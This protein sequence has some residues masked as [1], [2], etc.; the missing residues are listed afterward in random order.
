VP[1]ND[2]V[3]KTE[4]YQQLD[5]QIKAASPSEAVR[6]E[7]LQNLVR[8]TLASGLLFSAGSSELDAAGNATLAK[9]APALKEL[10]G[11]R[12]VIVGY[13]DDV[14]LGPTPQERF[15][16]NVELSK[17]RARAVAAALAAQGV[18][19][20]LIATVG[21]GETHPAASN[22]TSAGRAQNRR[23]EIDVVE[24]PA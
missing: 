6:I 15:G 3:P 1:Y 7:Q 24:A 9:L 21:L 5:A 13:T 23:V 2:L 20:G 11:Q 17:A 22:D 16:G 19:A 4:T 8:V 14:P 18:P 12:I 10:R